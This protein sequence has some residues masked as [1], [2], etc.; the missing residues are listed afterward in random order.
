MYIDNVYLYK[1]TH[2][3]TEKRFFENDSETY[4]SF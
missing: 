2:K 1:K 4:S 3:Q